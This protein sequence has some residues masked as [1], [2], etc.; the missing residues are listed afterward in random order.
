[1][2]LNDGTGQFTPATGTLSLPGVPESVAVGDL[3]RDGVLDI[4]VT[5]PGQGGNVG[6][7]S[8]AVFAGAC[9][10]P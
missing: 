2:L 10:G 8:I 6:S 3:D 5:I 7:S 1:V 9:S 4:V